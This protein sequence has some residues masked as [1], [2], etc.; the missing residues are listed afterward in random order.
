MRR[1]PLKWGGGGKGFLP[2]LGRQG[3]KWKRQ[4]VRNE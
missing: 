1:P 4:E 2:L 3:S